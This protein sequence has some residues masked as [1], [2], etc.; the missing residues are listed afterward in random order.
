MFQGAGNDVY[1]ISVG[2]RRRSS[3]G[4]A[5]YNVNV[6]TTKQA[7][8]SWTDQGGGKRRAGCLVLTVPDGAGPSL[9]CTH[10]LLTGRPLLQYRGGA[11]FA[12]S[13]RRRFDT[14]EC[15]DKPV[16]SLGCLLAN[17]AGGICRDQ[18]HYLCNVLRE[19]RPVIRP[20]PAPT[21]GLAGPPAPA[22][23]GPLALTSRSKPNTISSILAR[24][25]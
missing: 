20:G 14:A 4:Y 10:F 16:Q 8:N 23:N 12:A 2:A 21:R 9:C 6:F 22:W 18:S 1:T 24:K 25:T 19:R 3:L 11:Q 7:S 13:G 17:L 5:D 15:F